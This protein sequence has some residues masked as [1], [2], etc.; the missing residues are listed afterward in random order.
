MEVVINCM[1]DSSNHKRKDRGAENV[2][3]GTGARNDDVTSRG[4]GGSDNES[5]D[6]LGRRQGGE[7]GS[8]DG[9]RGG[10]GDGRTNDGPTSDQTPKKSRGALS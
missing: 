1:M 4:S 3:G 9:G 10:D 6:G 2:T 5:G 8:G 7:E